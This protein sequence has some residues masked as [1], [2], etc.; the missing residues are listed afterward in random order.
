MVSTRQISGINEFTAP[1]GATVA[2]GCTTD[3]MTMMETC[4]EYNF[5]QQT[6][7]PVT[8]YRA[9]GVVQGRY[10]GTASTS[11]DSPK[12][13]GVT[14]GASTEDIRLNTP[15]MAIFGE[16]LDAMVQNLG[17]TN[18]SYVSVG[19]ANAQVL[20]QG[21]TTGSVS[22]G[23][24]LQGIGVYIE[25]SNSQFP[26][27]PMSVSAS[28][29]AD[30][31][32][33]LFDLVS[34]GDIGAGDRF[35]EAPP[36]TQLKP[37]TSYVLVWRWNG[38]TWQ[39]LQRTTSDSEDSGA[40]TGFSIA[41]AYYLGAGLT[42]LSKNTGGNSLEIAVYGVANTETPRPPFVEGGHPVTTSWLHIPDD[43]EEGYQFRVLFVTNRGTLP[44]SG[45]I[46][47]Y[48]DF[49]QQEAAGTL[50][51]GKRVRD[52]PAAEPYTDPVIQ[53]VAD[54]F[55][56]V[57]CTDSLDA[58]TNTE[59]PITAIGVAIHWLDGGW[60]DRP[61]LIA[62]SYDGFYSGEWESTEYGAYVTGNSAYFHENAMVWTGCVS[63]GA[64]DPLYPMGAN[65]LVAVGSPNDP[66]ANHAPIG[67]VDASLGRVTASIDGYRPLY[68]I[69]PVFTVVGE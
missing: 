19:G 41:D 50:V 58:R 45:H 37:D 30:S 63:S 3:A 38:G 51:R 35:F 59:M 67:A 22:F 68:A 31:G 61:T 48:N 14:I 25:G 4:E 46:A 36:G 24:R 10:L 42:S 39:R 15:L 17:Q 11:E 55:K 12:A 21:F 8:G 62:D 26:D 33:K 49:V 44:T 69:S 1:Q 16:A 54:D 2:G 20:S 52:I 43:A 29:H 60:Q 64:A 7:D 32:G 27:G 53:A 34:P 6:S 66:S 47:D 57:V 5:Y 56:A 9:G 23:Y 28:V 65:N 40:L 13:T 18:N